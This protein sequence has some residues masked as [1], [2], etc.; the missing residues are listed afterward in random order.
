MGRTFSPAGPA[1]ILLIILG[2]GIASWIMPDPFFDNYFLL[3]IIPFV[4]PKPFYDGSWSV[5][6]ISAVKFVAQSGAALACCFLDKALSPEETGRMD[7][8]KGLTTI[9]TLVM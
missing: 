8:L 3:P 9:S 4:I 7:V 6:A 1:F 5:F 2:A